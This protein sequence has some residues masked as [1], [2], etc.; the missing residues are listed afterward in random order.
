[1]PNVLSGKIIA[2]TPANVLIGLTSSQVV[3]FNGARAGLALVNI[4]TSTVYLG[5]DGNNAILNAG[6]ALLPSGGT[7][8]MDDYTFSTGRVNAIAHSD[9]NILAVQEFVG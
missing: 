9:N 1:M 5:L 4:S 3:A 7:W 8:A 6:I 2:N